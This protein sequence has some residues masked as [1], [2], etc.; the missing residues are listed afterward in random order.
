M[1][2]RITIDPI[3][4]LEGHGKIEIFL[5]DAGDVE[6]AFLQIPELRGFEKFVEGRPA[7]DM[8]QITS[9]ICGVC[10]GAHH[11][12]ATR[13]LDDLFSVEPPPA[14][15]AVRETYYNLHMFEDHVL[16]FYFLAGPDFLV[17]SEAPASQRNILGLVEKVGL[18]TGKAVISIRKQARDLIE[19]IAGK[20]VHPVLG[21]PGGV[22]K[23]ADEE[24]RERLAAFAS[25][26]I[27]FSQASLQIFHDL[28]LGNDHY[29][30]LITSEVFH[31]RTYYMG[32][33]DDQ[34]KVSFYRGQVR[35]I[36][37]EGQEF[38]RFSPGE[39][40]SVIGEH[41]EPWSYIKFPFLRTVGWQGF[42]EGKESGIYRVAPIA[43]LNVASGMATPLAQQEYERLFET[44][45]GKPVH[46]TMAIHWARLIETLF[47]AERLAELAQAP[48]LTGR[49][50][51]N[52]DLKTPN[53]GVGIVEAPR[54]TI[55][56]HYRSDEQGMI[57]ACNMIVASLGNSAAMCMSVEQA[58]RNLITGGEVNDALLNQVEMAF[59]AY[60]PCFGC[61][62]HSMPGKM[63][64]QITLY[65]QNGS[66]FKRIVRNP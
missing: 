42:R 5:N 32:M 45:G 21:L 65:R 66:I 16:H 24:F 40:A 12:A 58:A 64:L 53:E 22:A 57:T 43:R 51:R 34:D 49:E 28:I 26:A 52:P 50:I 41:V 3:T 14:A 20:V 9:R 62:T 61:A 2:K 13:A 48:E 8:P 46:H 39:Y 54:G 44:F 25:D 60:D 59:R 18:E 30:E 29:R 19:A 15:H 33:V 56:H 47:A 27:G 37:P 11:M 63:P 10:P 36:D 35:V 4:R 6:R 31:H 1:G 17:G 55:I 38:T 7:E 23:A